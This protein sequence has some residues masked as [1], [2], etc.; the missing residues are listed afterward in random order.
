MPKPKGGRKLLDHYEILLYDYVK[1]G[2]D[3]GAGYCRVCQRTLKNTSKWR[4]MQHRYTKIL[5]IIIYI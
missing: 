3:K 4:L 5:I 1:V 2:N